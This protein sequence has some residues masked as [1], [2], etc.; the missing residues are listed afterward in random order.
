MKFTILHDGKGSP[1]IEW[2]QCIDRAG[3]P[4]LKRAWIRTRSAENDWAG[5]R[6]YL[7]IARVDNGSPNPSPDFPIFSDLP[8]EQILVAF[9]SNI[10]AITGCVPSDA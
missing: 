10:N 6:R 3:K 7:H 9:V 2:C 8:D 4:H 1:Y 5:V